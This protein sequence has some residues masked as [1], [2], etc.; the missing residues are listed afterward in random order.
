MGLEGP[1]KF[2][3]DLGPKGPPRCSQGPGSR[4]VD[5]GLSKVLRGS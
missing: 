5:A 1:E 2:K 4:I 3:K